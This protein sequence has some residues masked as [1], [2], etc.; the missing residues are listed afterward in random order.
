VK[1]LLSALVLALPI[2]FGLVYAQGTPETTATVPA[3]DTFH[4]VIMPMWH[5][6]YP[7]KD[8]AELRKASPELT[9]GI[10]K[11]A[12]SKLPGIL[13][14]KQAAWETGLAK[15]QAAG[16]AYVKAAA[17]TDDAALLKAAETLHS[18][19]EALVQVIRPVVPE[20]NQFHETLYVVQHTYVPAKDWAAVCKVS[21]QLQAKAEAVA[22]ATLSKRAAAKADLFKKASTDLVADAKALVAACGANQA[23]G[24]E[25]ATETLHTRYE[26]LT[27]IFE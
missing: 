9:T 4:E 6:S 12:D 3:L 16:D 10:K 13:R 8:Y 11:I 5:S 27:A 22:K 24:I 2:A 19:Y 15:L 14:E 20:M 1:K 25:K 7:A 26:G 18:S 17:G 23:A 21:G